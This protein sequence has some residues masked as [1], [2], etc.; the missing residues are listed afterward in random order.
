MQVRAAL[1]V[2]LVCALSS[3]TAAVSI[4][5]IPRVYNV[6]IRSDGALAPSE[7]VSADSEQP[8]SDDETAT[9]EPVE[10]G[11]EGEQREGKKDRQELPVLD[12]TRGAVQ[13]GVNYTQ[14]PLSRAYPLT[15]YTA[16]LLAHV[17]YLAPLHGGLILGPVPR[18]APIAQPVSPEQQHQQQ[19]Q[20]LQQQLQQ[21]QQ[22]QQAPRTLSL[23]RHAFENPQAPRPLS[24]PRRTFENQQAPRAPSLPRR[25]YED[26]DHESDF[27]EEEEEEDELNP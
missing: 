23:P 14:V 6:L 16:P 24:L 7:A 18:L 4:V 11:D 3:R 26:S 21:Q 8:L 1:A 2:L 9:S 22:Q 13:E 10:D 27:V 15:R 17:S 25:D 20:Q 19:Q 12:A 5:R